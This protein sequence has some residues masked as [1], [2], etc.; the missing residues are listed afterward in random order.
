MT[1]SSCRTGRGGSPGTGQVVAFRRLSV[2]RVPVEG[3]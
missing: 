3:M 2:F 1:G